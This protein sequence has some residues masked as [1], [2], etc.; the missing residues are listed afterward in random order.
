MTKS[1]YVELYADGVWAIPN[2]VDA[3][4]GDECKH[5]DNWWHCERYLTNQTSCVTINAPRRRPP[6]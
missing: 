5:S 3:K 4:D 2:P 1:N 6:A